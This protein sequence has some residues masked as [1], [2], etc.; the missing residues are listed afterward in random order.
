[1]KITPEILE[2][3]G[4]QLI[5]IQLTMSVANNQTQKLW[6]SFM[7]RLQEIGE[8]TNNEFISLQQYDI[9]YYTS[10]DP[11]RTFTKWAAVEVNEVQEIPSGMEHLEL[12]GGLYAVFHYKGMP[13]DPGI[14]QFIYGSWLPSSGY[15]L[16]HRPHFELIGPKYRKDSADSEEDLYIPIK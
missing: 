16:D 12:V 2:I 1:M 9:D 8:R 3:P 15:E 7:P 10:F 11:T 13:G 14:F 6:S 4:K 5:G